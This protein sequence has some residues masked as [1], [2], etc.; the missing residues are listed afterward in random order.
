M[1]C[2]NIL[3]IEAISLADSSYEAKGRV[4]YDSKSAALEIV[5]SCEFARYAK[6][7]IPGELKKRLG[8]ISASWLLT[9]ELNAP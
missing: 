1:D 3:I 5:S 9:R 4:K 7:P 8:K 2:G 6:S